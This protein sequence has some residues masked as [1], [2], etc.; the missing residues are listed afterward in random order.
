MNEKELAARFR[1]LLEAELADLRAQSEMTAEGRAPVA[2]DQQSVGRLSR[3]DALQ[4]QAMAQATEK[5]RHQ[6]LAQIEAA[7]R[8]MAAGEYGYCATCGEAIAEKRL[9]ADPAA[10]LCVGCSKGR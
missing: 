6:R 8:R 3:M 4:A 7:F 2:L 1:P 10:H 5:R 9:E